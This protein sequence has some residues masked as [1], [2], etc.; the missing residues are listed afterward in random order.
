MDAIV[1]IPSE[2][3]YV[4]NVSSEKVPHMTLLAF[5]DQS[6]NPN[7]PQMIGFL[8]HAASTSLKR[9]SL[10]VDH[11]GL[12]GPDEA[13]VVYFGGYGIKEIADFRSML[14]QNGAIKTAFNS[15]AQFPEWVPHLTLGFPATP[16]KK[17]TREFPGVRWVDF[18]KIAFW[19]GDFEGTEFM[20]KDQW[21]D[22]QEMEEMMAGEEM[23]A[24]LE[25]HGVKGQKWGVRRAAKKTARADSKFAKGAQA[26]K[27]T[28]AIHNGAVDEA[29]RALDKL[30][31]KYKGHDF[32]RQSPT[33]DKYYSAVEKAYIDALENSAKR[34][35]TNKSGTK[36]YGVI[37]HG[38]GKW[39]VIVRDVAHA[40]GSENF[41]IEV[42]IDDMGYIT[43]IKKQT[44][45]QQGE[46]A[47][48][49]I[50]SHFGV[51]G[52]KWGVRRRSGGGT[53]A[54]PDAVR[55]KEL[56]KLRRKG[57]TKALSNQEL[58]DL[59]K[60]MNLEQQLS[61]LSASKKKAGLKFVKDLL[62][63]GKTLSEASKAVKDVSKAV[64]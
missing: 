42:V 33:R 2:F 57:G 23:A 19:T 13:D 56:E 44:T 52:M 40:D 28:F 35:G 1:A 34:L 43:S 8:E 22:Q 47:V 51:K 17:D 27:T 62:E 18:D 11:R 59:V 4:W 58:Q 15:M 55:A 37:D 30:N 48:G 25:H 46:M 54:H 45:L 12:L 5:P 29:N 50:L 16:A 36:R 38:G 6:S 39:D 14:L 3:D 26:P 21:A 10:S 32:T 24:I 31:E 60:R 63:V 53:P 61:N 64:K 7:L 41:S 9:F 20:L 49:D